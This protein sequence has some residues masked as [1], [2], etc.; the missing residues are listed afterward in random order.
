MEIGFSD[1]LEDFD[2]EA[3]LSVNGSF[4]A[5][6]LRLDDKVFEKSEFS[7]FEISESFDDKLFLVRF[8][9]FSCVVISFLLE[10]FSSSIVGS[11]F[12]EDLCS[13]WDEV[14]KEAENQNKINQSMSG[15]DN[16]NTHISLALNLK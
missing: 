11:I 7:I 14:L 9:D 13:E 10:L 3:L 4:V 15:V 2:V 6:V 5:N 12:L 1:L 16:K 8:S